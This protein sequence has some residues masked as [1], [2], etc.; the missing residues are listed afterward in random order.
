MANSNQEPHV[1]ESTP[2]R[3]FNTIRNSSIDIREK[4]NTRRTYTFLGIIVLTVVLVATLLVAIIGGVIKNVADDQKNDPNAPPLD[5]NVQWTEITVGDADTKFGP[6]VLVNDTHKYTFPEKDSHLELIYAAFNRH[7]PRIYQLSGLSSHMD[8]TALYAMDDMLT[9]FHAAKGKTDILISYAYRS[10]KDQTALN[11]TI[12][13]GYSD[14]HTGCGVVLKYM[15]DDR[16]Y[17]LVSEGADPAYAWIPENCNR[18]GFVIRYPEAKAAVTGVS[19]Y[20]EYY[21]Y[22]GVAHATYMTEKDLC[23]EEYVDVLKDYTQKK[24][25]K[26]TG[27][28]GD[29]YEIYYVAVSGN[30]KVKVPENFVYT[31]S[32]TNEGGVIVTINRS[33]APAQP[34]ETN[35]VSKTVQD[36]AVPE[37]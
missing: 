32:G 17:D 33:K 3:S 27:A 15:V 8:R 5:K 25:L 19:D 14:H 23:L 12:A 22:V 1:S 21:R 6:L 29:K 20:T 24:P 18:Y 28:D 16:N 10:E 31:I 37:A 35:A 30:T 34:E 7:N 26:V 13:A 11:S 36:A 9:A 4:K 2:D